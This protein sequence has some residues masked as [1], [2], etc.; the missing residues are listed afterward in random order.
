MSQFIDFVHV[1]AAGDQDQLQLALNDE[2][3]VPPFDGLLMAVLMNR[4]SIVRTLLR[5]GRVDPSQKNNWVIR[6]ACFRDH[7]QVVSLLMDDPRVDP[8]AAHSDCLYHALRQRN[9]RLVEQLLTD[10]RV[11]NSRHMFQHWPQDAKLM[12]GL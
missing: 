12:T 3:F 4:V 9:S 2:H 6:M 1:C 10:P 5:D 11:A 8:S 7:V